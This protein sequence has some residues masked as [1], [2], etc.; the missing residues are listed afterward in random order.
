MGNKTH[1]LVQESWGQGL[2]LGTCMYELN[3]EAGLLS[4]AGEGLT[5]LNWALWRAAASGCSQLHTV[6]TP[7][8]MRSE[9][10]GFSVWLLTHPPYCGPTMRVPSSDQAVLNH[11]NSS[12]GDLAPPSGLSGHLHTRVHTHTYTHKRLEIGNG[13]GFSPVYFLWPHNQTVPSSLHSGS[14]SCQHLDVARAGQW[15]V[16][17][18]LLHWLK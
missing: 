16:G 9:A 17:L 8:P 5:H 14:S 10:E 6:T 15:E 3:E 12:P 7:L 4:T 1:R 13:R 2:M 18:F 11:S